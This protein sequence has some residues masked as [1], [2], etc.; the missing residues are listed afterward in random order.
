MTAG[1]LIHPRLKPHFFVLFC[2]RPHKRNFEPSFLRVKLKKSPSRHCKKAFKP[3]WQSSQSRK[4]FVIL[5]CLSSHRG[6]GE[7]TENAEK[8]S[9][10]KKLCVSLCALRLNT[11][12][13]TPCQARGC[14]WNGLCFFSASLVLRV[15]FVFKPPR[16]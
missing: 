9:W 15:S 7:L 6:H 14:R 11:I 10:P 8:R 3:T 1:R 5:N 16:H 4:Y 13:A 2:L 12:T